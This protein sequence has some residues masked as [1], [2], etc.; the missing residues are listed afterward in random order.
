MT[1]MS[2]RRLLITIERVL[3]HPAF[4]EIVTLEAK[5]LFLPFEEM[6]GTFWDILLIRL[7]ILSGHIIIDVDH[8][9]RA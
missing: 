6:F 7:A 2:G 5:S 4:S 9:M 3:Q 8:A 1:R